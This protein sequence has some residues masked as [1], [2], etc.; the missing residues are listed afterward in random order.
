MTGLF[1]CEIA[2]T[3]TTPIRNSFRYRSYLWL[4]DVDRLPQFRRPFAVLAG[5]HPEDHLGGQRARKIDRLL[6][7]GS[8]WGELALRAA[9]REARVH[10]VTLSQ[11]Q[12]APAR[13]RVAAAGYA[14]RVTIQLCDYRAVSGEYEAVISVE[15][16]EAVS[17]A[18]WPAYYFRTIDRVRRMWT[19]YLAYCEA[20]FRSRYLD[21][22]Q[23]VLRRPLKESA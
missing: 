12:R 14:D 13:D 19:F 2:H 4:V 11:E 17:E 6:E 5:F 21:V 23:F 16:I 1:A 15:M 22:H 8:G 9:A 18:V 10:S 3:R 7:I 20:G